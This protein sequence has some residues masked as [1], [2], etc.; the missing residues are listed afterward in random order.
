MHLN[1]IF[2]TRAAL[3]HVTQFISIAYEYWLSVV[4]SENR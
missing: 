4:I 3:L 2:E 1:D